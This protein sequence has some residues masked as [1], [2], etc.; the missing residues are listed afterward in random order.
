[1][2]AADFRAARALFA[3]EVARAP[4]YHEFH[5]W[6]GLAE[7]RLGNIAR[8]RTE[9]EAALENSTTAHEHDL[10]ATKLQRLSLLKH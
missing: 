4:E 8:A 1:M 9:L 10:Y 5:F 7:Y 2:E 6:L 3:R